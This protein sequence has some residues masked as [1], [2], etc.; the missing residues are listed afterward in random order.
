MSLIPRL[1]PDYGWS[2]IIAALQPSRGM[3]ERYE[4]A[5]AEK[6]G[7]SHGVMFSYGRA[8]LFALLKAWGLEDAE[9]V[10]PAYTCVVVPHAVVLSGNIP[11]FVDCAPGSFN[12]DLEGI[13]AA[14]SPQT[15]AVIATHLFG[16]PMDVESLSGIVR[17]AEQRFGR[18][19]YV[20]Q[21][22]AHSYGARWNGELVTSFG[23]AAV[24]GCNISKIINSIFGGM[25]TTCNEETCSALQEFRKN[26]CRSGGTVKTFRR[27]LYLLAV[28]AAFN[29]HV[30]GLVTMLERSGLLDR[31]VKYYDDAVIDFP[32]DWNL[33]ASEIEARVGMVQLGKYDRI[34]S[35]RIARAREYLRGFEGRDDI[36]VLPFDSGATYSHFVGIVEDQ[37]KW[38]R[39]YRSRGVQLGT[40][41][42]Y[43]VPQMSAYRQY[44]RQE[45]PVARSYAG[46]LVNFPVYRLPCRQ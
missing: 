42:E 32:S 41:I 25:V 15:G 34:V 33:L 27:L 39:E 21:D 38:I 43:V 37:G 16:Y 40:I 31:F 14:L 18:K 20:I 26:E 12:M 2:E 29:P 30:Y 46:H 9:V 45:Y 7:C 13:R 3:I 22:V 23:D 1:R 35:A 4:R 10:C 17:E 8:G 44:A 36:R 6:F 24:F 5:F 11:V 19:I 28:K